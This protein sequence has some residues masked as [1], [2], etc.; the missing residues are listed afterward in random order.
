MSYYDDSASAA[1]TNPYGNHTVVDTVP[2][3]MLHLIDSHWYGFPPLNDMWYGILAFFIS[4]TGILAVGGNFVVI[5]VFMCTKALRSPSNYYVV[6]LAISDFTLMACMCPPVVINSYYRTW[7]FGPTF[8]YVYAAIGSLTGCASIF[9][10]CLISYDRYNV[11]V[12]GIGGKPLTTGK[13]MLMILLVWLTSAA[14]TFAPFFGW[15]RYVPEGNMT[16]CGTDYLR[17]SILDQTYLWSYTT[18]CYFMTFVFIVYCYW[19]I[20]A[21]V[22]N[23]EKAMREQAKKM[24]V[25][26]LRGDADAQKKSADCKLAKIALINVSLWFMAWT[27]YAIINIAGL[28]NKEIVTP[29]F[30]IWGSVFAKANTV[31]NP[32]VYAISHPKYKGAL[33]QK[34]PWLQCAPDVPED[35]S[36]STASTTTTGGEEKA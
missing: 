1:Y 29:L 24:G 34:L 25:K 30:S 35:D 33:Y 13:A 26:S 27:P 31:Y 17:G 28:T 19:F 10:M 8:C 5:W 3:D 7:I 18:W 15:S 11:I 4:V 9:T 20:V 23:H 36:K 21:A 22:R 14:W 2:A 6:N 12:K 16:A 32:I